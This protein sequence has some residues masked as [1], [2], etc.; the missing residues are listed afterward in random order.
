MPAGSETLSLLSAMITPAVLI[1][2]SGTLIFSTATRLARVVD[3]V[4]TLSHQLDELYAGAEGDFP[5]ERRVEAERQIVLQ[6]RRGRLIQRSLTGLYVALGLFVSSTVAIAISPFLPHLDWLP[7]AFGI[8]GT[9]VLFYGC[10]TLVVETR[11]ALRSVDL[12]MAFVERLRV[13]YRSRVPPAR[14]EPPAQ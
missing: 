14:E 9:L 1:S 13:M 5:V 6:A 7:T 11:L 3:R 12:E 10:M 4:R 8:A 2:A